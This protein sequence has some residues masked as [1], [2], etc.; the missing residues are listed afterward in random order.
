MAASKA[1]LVYLF[2]NAGVDVSAKISNFTIEAADADGAFLSYAKAREGGDKDYVA[3]FTIEQ[4]Y[5]AGSLWTTMASQVGTTWTGYYTSDVSDLDDL[6]ATK[7]AFEFNAI[8]SIPN[9]VVIGGETTVSQKA[10]QTVELEWQLID[11][12]PATP[13]TSFTVGA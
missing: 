6:S 3:K 5:A 2:D 8:V 13:T 11:F 4:D 1:R 10:T 9:G 12:N 7:V